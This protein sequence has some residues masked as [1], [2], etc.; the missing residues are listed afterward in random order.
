MSLITHHDDI[1]SFGKRLITFLK[2][3]HGRE[4]DTIRLPSYQELLQ[5][6]SAGSLDGL[7]PEEVL[8]PGKLSVKLIIQVVSVGNDDDGGLFD[9]TLKEMSIKDH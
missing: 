2:L 1:A 7:L 9:T 5:V 3:L 8:T 6:L 4:D